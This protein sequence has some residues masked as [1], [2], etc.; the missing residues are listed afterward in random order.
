V[1]GEAWPEAYKNLGK[2]GDDYQ[3]R[4]DLEAALLKQAMDAGKLSRPQPRLLNE[5]PFDLNFDP[6]TIDF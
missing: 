3:P 2:F 6:A 4:R 5:P 1:T